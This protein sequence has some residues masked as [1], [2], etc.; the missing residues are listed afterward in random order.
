MR[1]HVD[2]ETLQLIE[3]PGFRNPVASLRF[4]RGDGARLEVVFLE[5]GTTPVAIGDPDTLGIEFGVK[6]RGRYDLG[7]LVHTADWTLPAEGAENPVYQC[8]PSFNT[9]ELDAAMQVGSTAELAE[10]TMMGEITWCE[11][12]GEPTSTRTFLVVV[13][14]DVNRG[15]EGSPVALITPEA[16]LSARA[17]RHDSSQ[18]LNQTAQELARE[19]I[20]AAAASHGHLPAEIY[21]GAVFDAD[22]LMGPEQQT[23]AGVMEAIDYWIT[24]NTLQ[25]PALD[26]LAIML[27]AATPSSLLYGGTYTFA[28]M[29]AA[30]LPYRLDPLSPYAEVRWLLLGCKVGSYGRAG[31]FAACED[32]GT[33]VH[34]PAIMNPYS[35][36]DSDDIV[37]CQIAPNS[38]YRPVH[39]LYPIQVVVDVISSTTA[40][41]SSSS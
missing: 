32:E 12:S 25:P 41:G 27:S 36:I 39:D 34:S 7:Y 21:T 8:S 2:L 13:E 23:P 15:T 22:T 35:S 31:D 11:G 19:N 28:D 16:W 9:A 6:L 26:T 5:N 37:R 20:G 24:H 38:L 30:F 3:G 18:V 10:A 29:L 14:N 17:V 40:A 1:L 33:D 4:K